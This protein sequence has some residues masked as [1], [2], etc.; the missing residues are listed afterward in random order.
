MKDVTAIEWIRTARRIALR[1]AGRVAAQDYVRDDLDLA[2]VLFGTPKFDDP[3]VGSGLAADPR[4]GLDDLSDQF[5]LIVEGLLKQHATEERLA[6]MRK[7]I[8]QRLVAA[9][10]KPSS[11]SLPA[12]FDPDRI[13]PEKLNGR[14]YPKREAGVLSEASKKAIAA[15]DER[16]A[17]L[18]AVHLVQRA[19]YVGL[20]RKL[21]ELADDQNRDVPG[22][23]C[24]HAEIK[25]GKGKAAE[26]DAK[27]KSWL[28][29]GRHRKD[30]VSRG[31]G[32]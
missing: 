14:A 27:I 23:L 22:R 26:A 20:S 25:F 9:R 8:K 18:A 2:R 30:A 21:L 31:D 16:D 13:D 19:L 24:G 15:Q 5:A 3:L 1:F 29:G 17:S 6:A 4:L 7:V 10:G 32:N 11:R 28:R 12:G